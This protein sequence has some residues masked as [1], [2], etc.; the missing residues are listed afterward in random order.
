MTS[1]VRHDSAFGPAKLMAAPLSCLQ[2]TPSMQSKHLFPSSIA[3]RGYCQ[4]PQ[5]WRCTVPHKSTPMN[6]IRMEF[7]LAK[8]LFNYSRKRV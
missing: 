1:S 5:Y 2:R 6:S 8:Y 7:P 3:L 4:M